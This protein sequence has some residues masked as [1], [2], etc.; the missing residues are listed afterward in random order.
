MNINKTQIKNLRAESHRMKLKPIVS[1]GQNGLNE[2]VQNEIEIALEHHELIKIRVPAMDKAEKKQMLE[3]ICSR[4][5]AVLIT[6]IG[7]VA[8]IYRRT[9]NADRFSKLLSG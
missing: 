4:T 5:N 1:I 6:A 3:S 8:I 2:N 7:N 9:E